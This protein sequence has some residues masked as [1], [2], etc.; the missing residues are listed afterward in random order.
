M[1]DNEKLSDEEIVK[2]VRSV[3]QDFYA[4]IMERYQDKLMRYATSLVKDE[5]KAADVVQGAFIKA[6]INLKS[7][8]VDK[9]FSSWIYRIVHNEAVNSFLKY[10]KEI[11]L[12]DDVDFKSEE[13]ISKDFD[14][15][16]VIARV[17]KCLKKMPL[18]YSEPL[19]LFY[20]EGK[21]YEEIGDILRMP[22]GTVAT[23][24]SRAKKIM[25][26]IC[27]KN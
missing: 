16:E 7:F 8:N 18:L 17:E 27:R 10:E 25:K 22:M 4:V 24:I 14:Q 12:P 21:S 23:R 1:D 3:D 13:D 11:R 9:K 2:K 26:N 6:F 5:Y 19:I 15:K 20:I